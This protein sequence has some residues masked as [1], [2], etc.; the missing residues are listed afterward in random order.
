MLSYDMQKPQSEKVNQAIA[1]WVKDG[2]VLLYL[3]GH[4]RGTHTCHAEWWTKAGHTSKTCLVTLAWGRIS[5]PP[6]WILPLMIILGL[7]RPATAR[8]FKSAIL[9]RAR[10][11]IPIN[12]TKRFSPLLQSGEDVYGIDA[13]VGEG[14]LI[15]VGLPSAYYG[16][17]EHG[18]E[19]LRDL[20]R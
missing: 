3:G 19:Q 12:T 14:R 13:K 4:K 6:V 20:V 5:R 18:P 11:F 8:A 17:G 2:G 7:D 10:Q 1:Q 9:S 16:S 15:S